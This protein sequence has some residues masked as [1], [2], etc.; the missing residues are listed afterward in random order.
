MAG[1]K[2][3]TLLGADVLALVAS[4]V[5]QQGGLFAFALVCR[6]LRDV[7][8]ARRSSGS[9]RTRFVTDVK[10]YA[11]SPFGFLWL[12][13]KSGC[14][15]SE[16]RLIAALARMGDLRMIAWAH[17]SAYTFMPTACHAAAEA[18]QLGALVALREQCN[19]PWSSKTCA[20]AAAAGHLHVV[21]YCIDNACPLDSTVTA[22]AASHPDINVL[23][24][25]LDAGCSLTADAC[26]SAAAAGHL[27]TLSF[28]RMDCAC[29]WDTRV[30]TRAARRGDM[31][32]LLWARQNYAP[33]GSEVL[34]IA[35]ESGF[36][37]IEAFALAE[38]CPTPSAWRR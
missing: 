30:C 9:S 20:V 5:E 26:A 37:E 13:R 32:M 33:W 12:R 29:P 23:C 3:I 6:D 22:S 1:V 21:Q 27:R 11:C 35:R 10:Q 25:L 19:C 31:A 14:A 16:N 38:G 4:H 28:L 8:Y 18:G 7:A 17:R 15:W 2:P 24:A 36:A 34:A